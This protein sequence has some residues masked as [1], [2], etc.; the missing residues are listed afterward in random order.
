MEKAKSKSV[1][2]RWKER[3]DWSF[4]GPRVGDEE[5]IG[6]RR[7]PWSRVQWIVVDGGGGGGGY[8]C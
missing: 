4:Q 5:K 2:R 7:C 1:A 6:W 8:F 3:N